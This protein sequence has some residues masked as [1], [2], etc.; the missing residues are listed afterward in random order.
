MAK[1]EDILT[2]LVLYA[3]QVI[4][5]TPGIDG[6][7]S[8]AITNATKQIKEQQRERVD[9]LGKIIYALLGCL[10]DSARSP[11]WRNDRA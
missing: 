8:T 3:K 1:I 4:T 2:E 5:W 6:A 11:D 10:P 7:I 9:N